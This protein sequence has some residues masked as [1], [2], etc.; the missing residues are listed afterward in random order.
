MEESYGYLTTDE[1]RDKDAI[2]AALLFSE[3]FFFYRSKN[4]WLS[5]VLARI[6]L[7]NDYF[8]EDLFTLTKEGQAGKKYIDRLMERLRKT[9][10]ERNQGDQNGGGV[11]LPRESEDQEW[12]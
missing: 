1:V 8:L 4:L 5:Q 3:M 11:G 6:Y 10:P 2:S 12:P 9:P 7:S